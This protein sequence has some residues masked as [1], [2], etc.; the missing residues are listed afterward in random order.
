MA[1]RVSPVVR[2]RR[3]AAELRRLR[4]AAGLTIDQVAARLECSAAKVSRFENGQVT[5]RIQDARELLELYGVAE[6]RREELLALVRQARAQGW[7]HE[8][9]D[10]LPAGMETY[11][12][13]ED[14][15]HRIQI[16]NTGLIP[17]LVQTERYA[18]EI[19][20]SFRD[21]PL[22]VVERQTRLRLGRQGILTRAAP[23]LLHL[24]IDE[25]VLRRQIGAPEVMAEQYRHLIEMARLDHVTIQ[26][27]P[28]TAGAHQSA[29]FSY[30]IVSFADPADPKVV[31]VGLLDGCVYRTEAEQVG[32]YG[33]AFDQ[34]AFIAL[35]PAGSVDFLAA[36]AQAPA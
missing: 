35:D 3:L 26:V 18:W 30:N 21:V 32:R 6:G 36:L 22:D 7:W 4:G 11:I 28:F 33:A 15:A 14:E 19:N 20:V 2:G 10:M 1:E 17:G 16:H 27:L 31:F 5:V 34:A 12:G 25:S 13:L 8:Y 9:A 23:A 24:V 29:A